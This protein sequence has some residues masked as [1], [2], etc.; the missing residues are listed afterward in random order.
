MQ[1]ARD[2]IEIAIGVGKRMAG[3]VIADQRLPAIHVLLRHVVR[4]LCEKRQRRADK[5]GR[6]EAPA[7][8]TGIHDHKK[9]SD[10]QG[11]ELQKTGARQAQ[12]RQVPALLGR[13]GERSQE[14]RHQ[15]DIGL[16]IVDAGQAERQK[17]QQDRA[18]PFFA[19]AWR[20][21]GAKQV[22]GNTANQPAESE[23][24]CRHAEQSPED[25]AQVV[26]KQAE[27]HEQERG[28]RRV[29]IALFRRGAALAIVAILTRQPVPGGL[30]EYGIDG[31][32]VRI[33]VGACKADDAHKRPEEQGCFQE[34]RSGR[35]IRQVAHRSYPGHKGW[36]VAKSASCN[37]LPRLGQ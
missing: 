12:G 23:Q 26:G 24:I 9:Q 34:G 3:A 2:Q 13:C 21:A 29:P 1:R 18:V 32:L 19:P 36:V 20:H 30:G 16:A 5:H 14:E 8:L 28:R 15:Q 35:L 11:I 6:G 17:E 25:A 33:Q 27:R 22:I 37:P 4:I 10:G 31:L 7:K